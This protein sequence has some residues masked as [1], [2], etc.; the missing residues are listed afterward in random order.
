M[1]RFTI[2]VAGMF[3]SPGVNKFTEETSSKV[4]SYVGLMPNWFKLS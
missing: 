2:F 3:S 4:I 1:K